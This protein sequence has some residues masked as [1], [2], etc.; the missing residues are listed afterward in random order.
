VASN[1]ALARIGPGGVSG[2]DDGTVRLR[3]MRI[4]TMDKRRTDGR[5]PGGKGE[6]AAETRRRRKAAMLRENLARR[7]AQRRERAPDGGAGRSG[8]R[9]ST[10]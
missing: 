5:D 1:A 2:R 3:P 9:E 8:G 7:K 4:A 10:E 6:S